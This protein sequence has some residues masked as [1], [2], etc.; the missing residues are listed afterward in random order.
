MLLIT[1]AAWARIHAQS[2]TCMYNPGHMPLRLCSSSPL[3]VSEMFFKQRNSQM[4]NSP[5]ATQN[6]YHDRKLDIVLIP[7]VVESASC[8]ALE[9]KVFLH[10]FRWQLE[11]HLSGH[12]PYFIR[13]YLLGEQTYITNI[14]DLATKPMP[15]YSLPPALSHKSNLGSQVAQVSL[16]LTC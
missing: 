4:E 2:G 12:R 14:S 3:V 6:M 15:P 16:E 1:V 8:Y 5:F 7:A 10:R 9:L 11:L 13:C